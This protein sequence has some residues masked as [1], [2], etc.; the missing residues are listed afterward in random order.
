LE[1]TRCQNCKR[2]DQLAGENPVQ[3]RPY[4]EETSSGRDS[5]F[6]H[7]HTSTCLFGSPCF[8]YDRDFCSLR[9]SFFEK[10]HSDRRQKRADESRKPSDGIENL[11]SYSKPGSLTGD[12]EGELS[13]GQHRYSNLASFTFCRGELRP[14]QHPQYFPRIAVAM[15]AR[16]GRVRV[17]TAPML[18]S[19]P[20]ET[21]KR[22]MNRSF[23][24]PI[25]SSTNVACFPL[26]I[27]PIRKAPTAGENP[28]KDES[29]AKMN[30]K[31]RARRNAV[32]LYS[33][34]L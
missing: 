32:S 34:S 7:H 21:K 12:N 28:R 16:I 24:G 33:W 29:K 10:A 20:I 1:K 6:C 25:L 26:I 14:V 2:G 3:P 31:D 30:P 11:R 13:P 8:H 19:V 27:R 9:R 22:T 15:T 4:Q 17:R 18:M 23:T 5:R